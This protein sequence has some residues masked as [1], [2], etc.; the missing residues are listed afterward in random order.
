MGIPSTRHA[1][2]SALEEQKEI[3]VGNK[4]ETTCWV[5]SPGRLPG[6]GWIRSRPLRMGDRRH[7][8]RQKTMHEQRCEKYAPWDYFYHQM[9]FIFQNSLQTRGGIRIPG[10]LNCNFW[11]SPPEIQIS[12]GTHIS[13]QSSGDSGTWHTGRIL[14]DEAQE[15]ALGLHT[16]EFRS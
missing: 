15:Q 10:R 5:N 13:I 12:S 1:M 16:H 9:Q 11:D 2:V 6:E 14:S 3:I 8:C 4:G 7:P